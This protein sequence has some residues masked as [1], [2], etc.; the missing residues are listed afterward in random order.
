MR[1][2]CALA[3]MIV[4]A[5]AP[6]E[7][8]LPTRGNRII[9]RPCSAVVRGQEISDKGRCI[10]ND[11]T[12]F[13]TEGCSIRLN[14]TPQ[15]VIAKVWS[16]RNPCRVTVDVEDEAFEVRVKKVNGC[17]VGRAFRFCV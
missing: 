12:A 6:A 14:R 3:L 4:P 7:Q 17:W 5:A 8:L 10:L 9:T 2:L 13:G 1:I 11:N 16:Y 15:G